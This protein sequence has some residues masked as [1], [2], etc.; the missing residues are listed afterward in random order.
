MLYK[1]GRMLCIILTRILFRIEVAGEQ[2]IP[3]AQG[4][5]LVAN[6]RSNFDPMFVVQK[7]HAQVHFM[8][9]AELFRNKLFGRLLLAVGTFPVERG[10]GDTG[11]IDWAKNVITQG[12]VLG[13]FPE[14]T[15]STDGTP[16]RPKSGAALIAMQ[17]GA[18]ILP[19]A[20]CFGERLRFRSKVTVRYGALI[21]NEELGISQAGSTHEIKVASRLM[22]DEIKKLM[23]AGS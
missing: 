12:R 9:K 5:I 20:V 18:D 21:K 13:M 10:R 14:G 16:L 17:T 6:H 22:M 3:Q 2:N 23:E 15:R 19:C 8:A 1:I 7:M 11:A 4:Y